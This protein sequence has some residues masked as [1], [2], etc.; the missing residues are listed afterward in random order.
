MNNFYVSEAVLKQISSYNLNEAEKTNL[1][2]CVG[3]YSRSKDLK[4]RIS[5]TQ[6]R[7]NQYWNSYPD[8]NASVELLDKK[9]T[10]IK[11]D[12]NPSGTIFANLFFAPFALLFSES[13]TQKLRKLIEENNK[14]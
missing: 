10:A 2:R 9:I 11:L 8:W 13:P 4:D 3:G 1:S 7:M 14:S 5:K 6:Y 12:G